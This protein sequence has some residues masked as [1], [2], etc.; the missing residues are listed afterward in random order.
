LADEF[1]RVGVAHYIGTSWEIPDGMG[2]KFATCLYDRLLPDGQTPG[3][4]F[5]RAVCDSRQG[6]FSIGSTL[7]TA[8][9]PTPTAWAA[10]QHH[11][12]RTDIVEPFRPSPSTTQEETAR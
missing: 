1:L 10:A 5:G 6:L 2:E 9:P 3:V 8:T 7:G 4:S 12:D 11:G